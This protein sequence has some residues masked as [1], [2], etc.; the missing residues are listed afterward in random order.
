MG[1]FSDLTAR[2]VYSTCNND[3]AKSSIQRS[4]IYKH[5]DKIQLQ[6]E[7]CHISPVLSSRA[8]RDSVPPTIAPDSKQLHKKIKSGIEY[9]AKKN[10]Y[11]DGEMVICL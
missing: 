4:Y 11:R 1:M 10:N 7:I 9:I 2:K 6:S 5:A 3:Y 8:C